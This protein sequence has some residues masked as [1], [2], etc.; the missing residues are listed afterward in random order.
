MLD[1]F[2]CDFPILTFDE[3]VLSPALGYLFRDSWLNAH[4]SIV[5]ILWKFAKFNT[6][7]GHVVAG[8]L[9]AHHDPY[10]GVAPTRAEVDIRRLRASLNLPLKTL[11]RSLIAPALK[12]VNSPFFR[13][14]PTCLST[15]Y[16]CVVH[17]H[18]ALQVCPVTS[19]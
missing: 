10:Q 6:L 19:Q 8:L 3:R 1:A 2:A 18:T 15:G 12:G 7:P 11:R 14:F 16:H 17:Q 5:A 4:E 13:F 9:R